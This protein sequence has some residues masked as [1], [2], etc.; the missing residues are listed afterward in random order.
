MANINEDG[1]KYTSI[2]TK[3]ETHNNYTDEGPDKLVVPKGAFVY[4]ETGPVWLLADT[5]AEWH[6]VAEAAKAKN[7]YVALNHIEPV[8][9]GR[10]WVYFWKK[11]AK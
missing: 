4:R 10:I 11:L 2:A 3:D 8:V 6:K 1:I 9:Y 5:S 7:Y